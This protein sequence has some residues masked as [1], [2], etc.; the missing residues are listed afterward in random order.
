MLITNPT[1]A[2]LQFSEIEVQ[3]QYP[4]GSPNGPFTATVTCPDDTILNGI[5]LVNPAVLDSEDTT[6]SCNF[7]AQL[8][9][10]DQG[11]ITAQAAG[12]SS[13]SS[14]NSQP[15]GF[16]VTPDDPSV[17][18]LIIGQCAQVNDT[19][20]PLSYQSLGA[21]KIISGTKPPR[22]GQTADLICSSK[23]YSYT[24]QFSVASESSCGSYIVSNTAVV[25]PVGGS[26]VAQ[27]ATVYLEVDACNSPVVALPQD[28]YDQPVADDTAPQV[29]Q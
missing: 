3:I 20:D 23:T 29:S 17:P 18:A 15:V 5:I 24:M 7:T 13:T 14:L 9:S 8:P 2:Q 1:T 27:S 6:L 12:I 10:S 28:D 11:T 16:A 22:D 25:N 4:A 21:P 26:Q 19:F